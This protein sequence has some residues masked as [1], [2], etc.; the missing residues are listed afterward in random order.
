MMM[1]S[2]DGDD[3]D[4]DIVTITIIFIINDV[5]DDDEYSSW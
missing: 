1:I 5:H 2:G 4:G 3:G